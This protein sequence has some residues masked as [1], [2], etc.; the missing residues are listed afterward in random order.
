MQQKQK[1]K[2]STAWEKCTDYWE[3]V[4]CQ[5][6]WNENYLVRIFLSYSYVSSSKGSPFIT[7]LGLSLFLYSL[8]LWGGGMTHLFE[9]YGKNSGVCLAQLC[10]HTAHRKQ[11]FSFLLLIVSNKAGNFG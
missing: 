6:T 8:C 4:H 3:L 11:E 9:K 1:I 10:P 2:A 7:T 5:C